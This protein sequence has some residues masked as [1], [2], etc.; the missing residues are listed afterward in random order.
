IV[1]ASRFRS[2]MVRLLRPHRPGFWPPERTP[3][4]SPSQRPPSRT[5]VSLSRPRARPSAPVP[6]MMF[7]AAGLPLI[8]SDPRRSPP[9]SGGAVEPLE[10]AGAGPA[11]PAAPSTE[12]VGFPV[13]PSPEPG[14]PGSP[15]PPLGSASLPDERLLNHRLIGR[16]IGEVL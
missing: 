3:L 8:G 10:L 2:M 16:Q 15:A 5:P 12:S 9:A 4:A 6:V 7:T 11:S 14:W 13:G 1:S